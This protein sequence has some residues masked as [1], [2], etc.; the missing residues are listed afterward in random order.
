MVFNYSITDADAYQAY[1]AAAMPS[2]G[3]SGAEVVVADY[4]SEAKEGSP[5][6]VTV[7]LRFPSQADAMAWYESAEYQAAIPLRTDNSERGIAVLCN[8]FGS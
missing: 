5:G 6:E 8:G 4:A 1:P 2:I 7:V 3:S